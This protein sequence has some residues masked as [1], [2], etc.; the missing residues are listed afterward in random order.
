MLLFLVLVALG[1]G[2]MWLNSFIHS[3]AFRHEVETKA[4][5][6]AG[7][8]VEIKQ[9]DFSIWSGVELEGLAIKVNTPQ[10]TV[11]AQIESV[12]CSYSLLALL[13]RR[14]QF[15]AVTLIK[16]Q[17]VLTQQPPSTVATPAPPPAPGTSAPDA[18]S[19]RRA[20][21]P[22]PCR[23][24]WKPP[25]FPTASLAIR[26]ATS[27]TKANLQGIQVSADTGGYYDG[28]D[29]TGKLRIATIA[30]PQ[31][32]TLTDFST[33]FTYRTGTISVNPIEAT[34]FGGKINGDYELDPERAFGSHR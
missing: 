30:L 5:A 29:V 22:R 23:W 7:A 3:D 25:A 33:P 13:S 15:N 18:R 9:I 24:C 14:L 16:P 28:K 34:A 26:D 6:A 17:I 8:P 21:R 1:P 2:T 31:N 27:A 12:H 11:A 32:L 10:G 19:R 4:S 20:A